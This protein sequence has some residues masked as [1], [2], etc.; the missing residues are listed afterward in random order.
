MWQI[1]KKYSMVAKAF[2]SKLIAPTHKNGA[3]KCL[4]RNFS[5]QKR[6]NGRFWAILSGL[7]IAVLSRALSSTECQN[8]VATRAANE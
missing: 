8:I 1:N 4:K 7:I 5:A 3:G 6:Q 2:P